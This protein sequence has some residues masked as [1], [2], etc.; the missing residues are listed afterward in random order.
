M[1]PDSI[2]QLAITVLAMFAVGG[3]AWVFIYPYLSGEAAASDRLDRISAGRNAAK[4]GGKAEPIELVLRKKSVENSIKELEKRQDNIERSP[5]LNIR[6]EQAGLKWTRTGY[7]IFS[8]VCGVVAFAANMYLMGMLLP[9][10]LSAVA[11]SI[12]FP[13]W[14]V[15]AARKKRFFKFMMEFPNALDVIVRGVK[16]GLPIGDC[17]RIVANE[18]SEP[19]RSEFRQI[20]EAQALNV[21]IPTAVEMLYQRIPL[22]ETNFFAIVITVQ[23]KSGGNLSEILS[24]LSKVLRDRKKLRAKV[25]ALSQESI[26]SAAI[27]GCLPLAVMGMLTIM[28]PKYISLLFDRQ[29]GQIMLFCAFAWMGVGAFIMKRMIDFDF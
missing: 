6:M 8:I 19:V 3:L 4:R 29:L 9:S 16:A 14:Y 12:I 1:F 10:I 17:I 23:Q 20:L 28:N 2:S 24:N 27:I 5:P 11:T 15:N 25:R 22:P 7:I 26:A 21:P 13:R 18:S